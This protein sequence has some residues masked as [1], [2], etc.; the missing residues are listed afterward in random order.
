MN[1]SSY[2]GGGKWSASGI[3]RARPLRCLL[4][5]PGGPNGSNRAPGGMLPLKTTHHRYITVNNSFL[6]YSMFYY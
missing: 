2:P 5:I 6:S 1:M 4:S 3:P